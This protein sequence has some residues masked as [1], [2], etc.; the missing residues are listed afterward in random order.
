MGDGE[1][2]AVGDR[3]LLA[4]RPP[5]FDSPTTRGLFDPTTGVYWASDSFA[6][7]MPTPVRDAHDL[8]EADW[9]AGMAMFDHYVSP[10]L[11]LV[12]D[13]RFQAT[14]DRVAALAPTVVAGCHTP[15]ITGARVA[16]AI[17]AAR[18]LPTRTVPPE[19]DQAVLEE[20]LVQLSARAA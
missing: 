5:V 6:A 9:I 19:P 1:S 18:L 11:A 2:L 3:T 15:V 12:D 20:I 7:P 13:T 14:V 10:W 8:D 16:A 4:V 17:E